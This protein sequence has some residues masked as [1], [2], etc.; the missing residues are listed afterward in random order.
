MMNL[1]VYQPYFISHSTIIEYQKYY[2]NIV[3][4]G[5][6]LSLI[7]ILERHLLSKKQMSRL[8]FKV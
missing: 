3:D 1:K 5:E 6:K 7:D 4:K 2:D 8:F